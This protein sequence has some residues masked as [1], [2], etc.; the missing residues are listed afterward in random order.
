MDEDLLADLEGLS[1]DERDIEIDENG[2]AMSLDELLKASR[3]GERVSVFALIPQLEADIARFGDEE[4]EDM[5]ELLASAGA[6]NQNFNFLMQLGELPALITAEIE[7]THKFV[8]SSYD[9][10]LSDLARLVPSPVDYCRAVAEIG[11][12]LKAIRKSEA[13]LKLFLPPD[14]VLAILM[15]GLQNFKAK[16]LPNLAE[17][18]E[19]CKKCIR[20]NDFLK[21]VSAFIAARLSKVA[22][23]VRELVGTLTASQLLIGVGSLKQLAATPA[24]NLAS[25]GVKDLSSLR[26]SSRVRATG[27]LFHS[28]VVQGLPPEIVKQAL[29]ILSGKVILAARVDMAQASPEGHLGR[30]YLEEV[31]QKIDKLLAPPDHVRP[32]ALPVPKD[33]KS[34]KRGGRRFRKMKERMQV[35]ELRKAQNKME[36][37]KEEQTVTD[38]YGEEVGLGLSRQVNVEINRNT[39]ARMS[40]AMVSRLQQQKSN[41]SLDTLELPLEPPSKKQ[42]SD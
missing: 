35:S 26:T 37:G 7:H 40:K 21:E 25:F 11:D 36:F 23:N 31:Q 34:K 30:K 17:V 12:D 29:R 19:A 13:V 18:V 33:Q 2:N 20:L 27:Y 24:C 6:E 42:K 32:K 16:P 5:L 39:D 10:V 38:V 14:K 4:E 8:Q 15:A 9:A 1:G 22:P 41:P 28:E 3:E